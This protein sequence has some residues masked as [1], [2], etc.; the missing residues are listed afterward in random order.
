M[1][2]GQ[3]IINELQSQIPNIEY[4]RYFKHI[5]FNNQTSTS[6]IYNY[7]VPNIFILKWIQNKYKKSMEE[8]LDNKI[9]INIKIHK[10]ELVDTQTK[11]NNIDNINKIKNIESTIT[12]PSLTFDSFVVGPSNEFAFIS[13]KQVAK[14]PGTLYN[15]LFLYGGVGL[16]K[17]HLLQ[18]IANE[19]LNENY[20]I[21]YLSAEQ[22]MNDMSK[23]IT[24]K[25]MSKFREKYRNCDILLID[26]IQFFSGK[27]KLQEEFFHTFNELHNNNKQIVLTSD[28][29]PSNIK[30]LEERL[31][32]RF[33]WGLL[34]NIQPPDLETKIGIIKK[35]CEIDDI[36]LTNDI[37]LYI[38]TH[39]DTNIREIEG[40]LIKLNAY[41]N[42]MNLEEITITM[43]KNVLKEHI[44]AKKENVTIDDIINTVSKELNIKPS[45]IKSKIR[46]K[47]ITHARRIVIYLIKEMTSHSM[48]YLAQYFEMK[49]HSAISHNIKKMKETLK[50]NKNENII[51]EEIKNK[52]LNKK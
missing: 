1:K 10:E 49:D 30:G 29:Q 28:K 48:S 21:L 39:I 38:A 34:T 18:S 32:S 5:I 45:E 15:P 16:G 36:S 11:N 46:N 20:K 26:D 52:I 3:E 24:N 2:T 23:N 13:A 51:L 14:R 12:N 25:S 17:T 6:S 35:K 9:T 8:K 27:D 7:E 33:E 4:E 31:Q 19:N 47:P 37:I 41:A 42:L 43:V 50:N 22:L 44:K 40:I